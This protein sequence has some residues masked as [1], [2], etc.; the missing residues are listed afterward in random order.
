MT[1]ANRF[2]E[3]AI[4]FAIPLALAGSSAVARAEIPVEAKIYGFLN[5]QVEGVWAKGGST[6]YETRGRVSDGNSRLGFRGSIGLAETTKALWQLEAGLNFEQGGVSGQGFF[7]TLVSRN[8][9]VG[10]EDSRFGRLVAGNRDS[11]YRTLVGSGGEFGGNIGL[12]LQGLD[13]W[14]NTSAQMTGNPNSLFSRGEARYRDSIH[15]DSPTWHG[16]RLAASL[17]FDEAMSDGG[18]RDRV[19][20]AAAY[21]LGAFKVGA[22]FDFQ[23]NTGVDVEQLQRGFALHT[24]ALNDTATY[25]YKVIA[26]YDFPTKTYLGVGVERSNYGY[27]LFVPP[28]SSDFYARVQTGTF[29]Q[30]GAVVSLAQSLGDHLTLM[31]SFGKLGNLGNAA[32]FGTGADYSATQYS[33]GAKYGFNEHFATYAYFT[34]I[35]NKPGQD[36]NLG[37]SPLYTNN[38]GTADAYLAPGDSP[39]AL[40]VGLIARF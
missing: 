11:A 25:Y 15:Y 37:Q 5:A 8:S 32:V 16:L 9:F 7:S 40:G 21:Q 30:Y 2:R 12:T 31:G 14:N 6:P 27:S 3:T 34:D 35:R 33:L 17:G 1:R 22:G 36:V 24:G 23:P 38:V 13:L 18:R 20:V 28:S 29:S 4:L 39:R 19:S 26:S 10:I